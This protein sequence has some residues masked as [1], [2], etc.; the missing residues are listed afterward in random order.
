[1]RSMAKTKGLTLIEV[2]VALFI[3]SIAGAAIIRA[4]TEHLSAIGQIEE[5]TVATWVAN[6]RLNQMRTSPTWPPKNNQKGSVDM[7]DRTWY[8]Q[9]IVKSTNDADLRSITIRVGLDN[10]YT[11]TVTD[12]TTF[13]AKPTQG[14]EL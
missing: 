13:L 11:S 6:N 3:F 7:A 10:T 4:A 12:V 2:L 1:M 8:W 5:I 14:T 9:Q